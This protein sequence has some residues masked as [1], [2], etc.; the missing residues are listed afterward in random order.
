MDHF[1]CLH[2]V[3]RMKTSID[4]Q[5]RTTAC[6]SQSTGCEHTPTEPVFSALQRRIGTYTVMHRNLGGGAI[7]SLTERALSLGWTIVKI[8]VFFA[9]N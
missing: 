2:S 5:S 7:V 3:V 4:R 8:L 6:H 1:I 9:L